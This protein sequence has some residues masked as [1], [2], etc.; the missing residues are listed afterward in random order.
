MAKAHY[1]PGIAWLVTYRKAMTDEVDANKLH[2]EIR[3]RRFQHAV[4]FLHA[5]FEQ[6]GI[7]EITEGGSPS[8]QFKNHATQG[9]PVQQVNDHLKSL[10]QKGF[11]RLYNQAA[12]QLS[13]V[14]QPQFRSSIR[15]LL[16]WTLE[17][18][19]T[20]L[21]SEALP[22]KLTGRI[23][24][25]AV[26]VDTIDQLPVLKP[27][28]AHLREEVDRESI[29][30]AV[31][32]VSREAARNFVIEILKSIN[33]MVV[34]S[35]FTIDGQVLSPEQ[36]DAAIDTKFRS[37]TKDDALMLIAAMGE[38]KDKKAYHSAT[39]RVR[40]F[41]TWANKSNW[42]S[43][44]GEEITQSGGR[45]RVSTDTNKADQ[46]SRPTRPK[47][48]KT[49][50]VKKAAAPKKTIAKRKAAQEKP[51]RAASDKAAK[52]EEKRKAA[53]AKRE[54]KLKGKQAKLDRQKERDQRRQEKEAKRNRKREEQIAA[55]A[56]RA[57]DKADKEA[58]RAAAALAQQAA[59][60]A[61]EE[62]QRRADEEFRT[63][64]I[65]KQQSKRDQQTAE[66]RI[67]SDLQTAVR[68]LPSRDT[69]EETLPNIDSID[70]RKLPFKF[71]AWRNHYI[72]GNRR[73]AMNLLMSYVFNRWLENQHVKFDSEKEISADNI[74]E[75]KNHSLD[76][77]R[78]RMK[79]KKLTLTLTYQLCFNGTS[80][81]KQCEALVKDLELGELQ[82]G[83]ILNHCIHW[84]VVSGFGSK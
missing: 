31:L 58:A 27:Y 7:V 66:Q 71:M 30:Q 1:C 45:P 82:I 40:Q 70:S 81:T 12:S 22:A 37:L 39:Y 78:D 46:K 75:E 68:A 17:Q 55:Q 34:D 10:D 73:E 61:E 48:A 64:Q 63:K 72:E 23:A 4:L 65:A 53:A 56:K 15:A 38:D 43:F 42:I 62:K 33:A 69:L 60:K 57:Q 76:L 83:A 2:P 49:V 5:L 26:P 50:K 11:L 36:F 32:R 84:I 20:A 25:D 24:Y 74:A 29:S 14:Q 35:K 44:S 6:L 9:D 41:I 79:G 54:A 59:L 8:L 52:Q 13:N 19:I 3:N 80:F 21:G 28:I 77:R 67:I 51:A 16:S 47:K 18:Q